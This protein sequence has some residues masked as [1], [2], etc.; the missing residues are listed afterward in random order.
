VTSRCTGSSYNN[1]A[2]SDCPYTCHQTPTAL[3]Q[4]IKSTLG[5]RKCPKST[6][7]APNSLVNEPRFPA[8]Q[9]TKPQRVNESWYPA[10]CVRMWFWSV[11]RLC[12]SVHGRV[13]AASLTQNNSITLSLAHLVDE[14]L[15]IVIQTA[16][17]CSSMTTFSE[18]F[19]RWRDKL[20]SVVHQVEPRAADASW[21][22]SSSSPS[23]ACTTTIAQHH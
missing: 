19:T 1:A 14:G 6:T 7:R 17:S 12:L 13:H 10:C 16:H 22:G 2:W 8:L 3:N 20:A 18:S 5:Q 23:F 4:S 15:T 9:S 11:T 21:T